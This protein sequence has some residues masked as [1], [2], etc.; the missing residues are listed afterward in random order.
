MKIYKQLY[1]FSLNTVQWITLILSLFLFTGGALVT[2]YATDMTSQEVLLRWD[3]LLLTV[4]CTVLLLLLFS[5]IAGLIC[6]N[7]AVYKPLLFWLV[8]LWTIL[9]GAVL[10][11]FSKTVPA[12]DAYSVYAAAE[13]LAS[14]DTSVIHP[15]DSYLS[16]YPQQVGLMAFFEILIRIWNLFSISFPAYH[17]IKVL[18]VFL[19]CAAIFFQYR[20]VHILWENDFVDC[21]YLLLA[22]A[23]L[24]M[25]MYG[26]FVYGEIPSFTAFSMGLYF[27]LKLFRKPDGK[28]PIIPG[29]CCVLF[30]SLSVMLR[31]NSLILIIAVVLVLILE[32]LRSKQLLLFILAVA[33]TICS[34]G[35]LPLTRE[36]YELRSGST[37]R[38]G[39]T[40]MSYFAMGMQE[41]S[42]AD[43][44]YNGFNFD[45]Y[46]ATGMDSAQTNEIARRAIEE[47]LTYFAEHPRYALSFY[48]EKHLSQWADGTYASRQATLA[49]FGGRHPFFVSLYEGDLS[50]LYINYCNLYQN[51]LYLG[52]LIFCVTQMRQSGKLR[53]RSIE[54]AGEPVGNGKDESAADS[55][56]NGKDESVA[57]SVG[58][59]KAESAADAAGNGKV[60]IA[61]DSAGN[62]KT[63]NALT[64]LPVY[65]GFIGVI[66]GF[67]FHIIWEAN[68]RYI[69]VYGLLLMP[70]A[71]KGISVIFQG[72]QSLKAHESLPR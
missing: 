59:G 2:C 11:V 68:S 58:N 48:A 22:G 63:G 37:L 62:K 34:V 54:G 16:Y 44:W 12:A 50:H 32:W 49:T 40:A 60:E 5:A 38:S 21:I 61:V 20:S 19:L 65:I 28:H 8:M 9:T 67:L 47:R 27:L 52:A 10:I 70:Y 25:L 1:H 57:D 7:S 66:G 45:T 30:F 17:F 13:S 3:N 72:L 39:V 56:G 36:Y 69:F 4:P 41:S 71:A 46:Q 35:I 18:Y 31:K 42:R 24:P 43:G 53:R 6:R 15:T 51:V 55:V 64:G 26:S 29:I 14:G 33:C 23:N